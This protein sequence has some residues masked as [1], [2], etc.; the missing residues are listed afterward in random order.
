[1]HQEA[2]AR[3]SSEQLEFYS[4]ARWRI[5]ALPCK[6]LSVGAMNSVIIACT[7]LHNMIIE[8]E[9]ETENTNNSI[10]LTIFR[11]DFWLKT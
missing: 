11:M 10:Y 9:W 1:M 6:L 7:I 8:D 3:T 2:Q 4:Q 5:L